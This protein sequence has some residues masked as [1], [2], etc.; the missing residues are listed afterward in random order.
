[1]ARNN[2]SQPEIVK[3]GG[4][5]FHDEGDIIEKINKLA[6]DINKYKNQ[7]KIEDINVIGQGY[8]E[9]CK[10]V[11]YQKSFKKWNLFRFIQLNIKIK[12]W[13]FQNKLKG[14]VK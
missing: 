11:F 8:L 1:M 13:K 12:I 2:S 9:F 3:E 4:L 5:L 10:E 7:I 6:L 14:L